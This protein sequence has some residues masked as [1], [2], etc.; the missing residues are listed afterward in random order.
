VAP[1]DVRRGVGP[2]LKLTA[3]HTKVKQATILNQLLL[4]DGGRVDREEVGPEAFHGFGA[5][6]A[7]LAE[8]V[9]RLEGAIAF[10]VIDD[11]AG[12]R[13]TYVGQRRK[14]RPVGGVDVDLELRAKRLGVVDFDQAAALSSIG[15]PMPG[16]RDQAEDNERSYR[17]L[18]GATQKA[19]STRGFRG[20]VGGHRMADVAVGLRT[21]SKEGDSP[22]FPH[23]ASGRL[24]QS[25]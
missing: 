16:E 8:V 25:P 15:Q 20:R 10:S 23:R 1:P 24:G 14:L 13:L 6:A 21:V 5:D 12:E 3:V 22:I 7:D 4:G 9:E 18:V 11:P 17:A 19:L 2:V